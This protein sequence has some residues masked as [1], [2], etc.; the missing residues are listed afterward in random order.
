MK[1]LAVLCFACLPVSS[2]AFLDHFDGTAL[3]AHWDL[4]SEGSFWTHSVSGGELRVTALSGPFGFDEVGIYTNVEG[5]SDFAAEVRVLW[6]AGTFQT[7]TFGLSEQF[8]FFNPRIGTI[9]Y[10]S[11]PATGSVVTATLNGGG[12]G[13][14]VAPPANQFHVFRMTRTGTL[15][16]A[17]VDGNLLAEINPGSSM[18]GN[19]V[20][21]HFGGPE[22]EEF[23]EFRIDYVSV[24]PEP[25]TAAA[26]GLGLAAFARGRKKAR[27]GR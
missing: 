20:F 24:V 21:L 15:V 12:N 2:F 1:R 16:Q 4:F 8:P 23:G 14:Q 11:R 7:F 13:S 17:F 6:D 10:H 5:Y 9:G 3:G 22:T 25:F 18:G 27:K 19:Q 26:L